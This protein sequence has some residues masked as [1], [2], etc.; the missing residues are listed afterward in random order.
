MASSQSN[1]GSPKPTPTSSPKHS[2]Q[3]SPETSTA[4]TTK[5]PKAKP[6]AVRFQLADGQWHH[7]KKWRV[8]GR[9]CM[10]MPGLTST[11]CTALRA[12]QCR[13]ADAQFALPR[14]GL[15]ATAD[16][17]VREVIVCALWRHYKK[18][19]VVVQ[20]SA[21]GEWVLEP[22]SNTTAGQLQALSRTQGAQQRD[23]GE[24]ALH[25]LHTGR[26]KKRGSTLFSTTD[27]LYW[28]QT[29]RGTRPR[30][31]ASPQDAEF[32]AEDD[33]ND[34]SAF[35]SAS[36]RALAKQVKSLEACIR[37]LKSEPVDEKKMEKKVTAR[38][39]GGGE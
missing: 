18:H 27:V 14:A 11:F 8:V 23:A 22:Y 38:G 15:V 1:K 39:G 26:A 32:D 13:S 34:I 9:D 4:G 19:I 16:K 29:Q 5:K 24:Y 25:L 7:A 36:T 12:D 17:Q 30:Q 10:T 3:T 2:A 37:R 31:V 6:A 35:S 21:T 28:R 20:H 33:I